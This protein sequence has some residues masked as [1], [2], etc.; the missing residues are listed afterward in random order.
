[1]NWGTESLFATGKLLRLLHSLTSATDLPRPVMACGRFLPASLSKGSNQADRGVGCWEATPAA[2]N[3]VVSQLFDVHDEPVHCP[4]GRCKLHP[5]CF[6]WLAVTPSAVCLDSSHCWFCTRFHKNQLCTAKFTECHQPYH[7]VAEQLGRRQLAL[8]S[9]FLT[10]MEL[11]TW[12][13]GT[14]VK[15]FLS[16]KK[17]NLTSCFCNLLRSCFDISNIIVLL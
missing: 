15:S 1:M 5:Q 3:S 9:C 6:W 13:W 8:M 7:R 16:A 10:M 4:S 12:S 2:V 14:T 11:Y 17:M